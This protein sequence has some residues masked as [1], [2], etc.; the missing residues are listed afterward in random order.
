ML[1]IFFT[2]LLFASYLVSH[3]QISVGAGQG[4]STWLAVDK[5]IQEQKFQAALDGTKIIFERAQ[6]EKNFLLQ[7]EA[8]VRSAQ[9]EIGLG[10]FEGAVKNFRDRPWPQQAEAQVLLNLY[11][12]QSLMSYSQRYRWE[13]SH[14][15]T[16]ESKTPVDLKA[17]TLQDLALEIKK[18]LDVALTYSHVMQQPTS[19]FFKKYVA[20]GT[21]PD[22][23][24][25]W[26]RN[27]VIDTATSF[28]ADT[29][30]W[31]PSQV[32]EIY[33]ISIKSLLK[34]PRPQRISASELKVHPVEMMASWLSENRGFL[35]SN[36]KTEAAL[37]AQYALIE[38]L[39]TVITDQESRLI[40]LSELVKVQ[41]EN[42]NNRWWSRGQAML[43]GF[44]QSL[45]EKKFPRR[46]MDGLS[47]AEAGAKAF[48]GSIGAQQCLH[49]IS[50]IRAPDYAFQNMSA[51]TTQRQSLSVRYKNI[52]KLFFRAYKM[53]FDRQ[54]LRYKGDQILGGRDSEF[55][56]EML[57][58]KASYEWSLDLEETK[59]FLLHRRLVQP[60][61]QEKGYYLIYA[62]TQNDFNGANDEVHQT[63]IFI[64]DYVL[65]LREYSLNQKVE[66]Q[67]LRGLD[68]VGVAEV[69]VQLYRFDYNK[70][71]ASVVSAGKSDKNGIVVFSRPPVDPHRYWN[72]FATAKKDDNY[73]LISQVN[74]P[75]NYEATRS[76]QSMIFI[77]RA[78]YRPGQKVQFKMS[79]FEGLKSDYKVVG[80]GQDVTVYLHDPNAQEVG[81]LKLTTN[82]FGTV[83]GEFVIPSGRPLGAWRLQ[84]S[85]SGFAMLRVEEYKRPTFE[86]NL[87]DPTQALH[88]N[89]KANLRGEAKYFFGQPVTTGKIRYR[90]SRSM[91]VFYEDS[92]WRYLVNAISVQVA[93]GEVTV[94]SN[95]QFDIEFTPQG[96]EALAK[97]EDRL[98]YSYTV[99][100][101]FTDEGGE[102]RSASRSYRIGFLTLESSLRFNQQIFEPSEAIE[103][104][105]VLS[106]LDGKPRSGFANYKIFSVQQ[107]Q[108]TLLPADLENEIVESPYIHEHDK[109]RAR[110][111]V[112]FDAHQIMSRWPIAGMVSSGVFKHEANGIAKAI[113]KDFLNPGVYRLQYEI[114]DDFG[115]TFQLKKDFIIGAKKSPALPLVL[116]AKKEIYSVGSTAQVFVGSGFEDQEV[117]WQVYRGKELIQDQRLKPNRLGFIEI[118]I[119]PKDRGGFEIRAHVLRDYQNIELRQRIFVPWDDKAL[120]LEIAT[121][122]DRVL[123]G[124]KEVVRLTVKGPKGELLTSGGA[125]VL[126]LMYDR[127]LDLFAPYSLSDFQM[128]YPSYG[129]NF[130]VRYSNQSNSGFHVWGTFNSNSNGFVLYNSNLNMLSGYAIGG[131]GQR[132]GLGYFEKGVPMAAAV[133]ESFDGVV[134]AKSMN[135]EISSKGGR[136]REMADD[137]AKGSEILTQGSGGGGIEK[138]SPEQMRSNFSETAFFKPQLLLDAKGGVS[139]EYQMPDSLTSWK[140]YAQAMTKDMLSGLVG[141]EV[142]SFKELMV[143]PYMPRFLREG[144][145]AEI[146]VVVSNSSNKSMQGK[147]KLQIEDSETMKAANL[148]FGLSFG[149]LSQDFQ[150]G[151]NSSSHVNFLVKAPAKLKRYSFRVVAEV[152]GVSDGELREL[153]I[154]PSRMHLTQSRF[155]SLKGN[156]SKSVVFEDLRSANKDSTMLQD[157]LVATVDA[158]L[159]FSLLQALPSILNSPYQCSE[160]I[161]NK[162][163]T[164]GI[165]S[166][167][168]N[169]YPQLAKMAK[170]FS[171]RKTALE[172]FNEADAN[173]RMVL[174]ES[175]W[176]NSARGGVENDE[177][178]SNVLDP[179][180]AKEEQKKALIKLKKMQ[181]DSGAFPWFE[182]GRPDEFMTLYMLIGFSR[183]LEFKA[184]VPKEAVV[185][186]WKYT[187]QWIEN[188]IGEMVAK[189]Y[190]WEMVTTVLFALSSYPDETWSGGV[191]TSVFREK[192]LNFS[193]SHWKEHAPRVKAYLALVLNRE[194]RTE[195]AKLVWDSIMDSA[196]TSEDFGTYWQPEDR[197]WIWYRDT[198]ESQAFGLRS[199][200]ELARG[201]ART[202]G[203]VQWLFLNKKLN[204]W[205]STRATAEVIYSVAKYLEVEK[206]IGLKEEILVD[207]GTQSTSMVFSPE[208][209]AGRKNQIV[210]EGP[211]LNPDKNSKI[212]FQNRSANLAFASATWHFSTERLPE[213]G[214]GDFFS[215][216]RT[217]FVRQNKSGR[218]QP[219]EWTLKPLKSGDV[220]KVGDQVEVQLSL[221]SKHEAEYV[222]VRDPRAAGLEPENAISGYK[223][224]QGLS[225][226]EEVRDSGSNFFMSSIPV[227]EAT[228]RYRLRANMAGTFRL[229]PATVQSFYAPEFN[230][231]SSGFVLK[232]IP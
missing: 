104:T 133:S 227:G 172:K 167:F 34:N 177:I 111:E 57:A 65:S 54:V 64:S 214:S 17:W 3:A 199:I 211:K 204:Q 182:G 110:Y 131:L 145:L 44:Y 173:R 200:M 165:L 20:K 149:S 179:V 52:S 143:R 128:I 16:I 46:M 108:K 55:Y 187:S 181:L 140:F 125:E 144:D 5:L 22:E 188:Q 58:S 89:K 73:A 98:N 112:S 192:L 88:L 225:W 129:G 62:A 86:V 10:S 18:S 115:K 197:A 216:E 92:Y 40:I 176:L 193:F 14:R 75:Q 224:G 93:Q 68:G 189:N 150:V 9:L 81:K 215:I 53:D 70:G 63:G 210:I 35:L 218:G 80:K 43:S 41:S 203:F 154:L 47:A 26:F 155:V 226:Y 171:K 228:F 160:L 185:K 202:E 223:W 232:V 66:I 219:G 132:S 84:S 180:L 23:V 158:Q 61:I 124:A 45:P 116:F 126:A 139:F 174:E 209:Y 83:A 67:V 90:I 168:Y 157:R 29:N 148:D 114:Q 38:F 91:G 69:P 56:K 78:I 30:F 212:T 120:K 6:K 169:Q 7:A 135:A 13:I 119:A 231:Y 164:T 51:D 59:D 184:E 113:L 123:P 175:P 127:S 21:F 76:K 50:V 97:K 117:D 107:P 213:K 222:H 230:A 194:K 136:S 152:K 71:D 201:D 198:V 217:Y 85:I 74:F 96:E 1:R 12:A 87:L 94:D 118:P 31:T 8:M 206:K 101:D 102:T 72:Y 106:Q 195:S 196:K 205:K 170:Q 146:R 28:F 32:A 122:R 191:F 105:A 134:S 183:A 82:E 42:R 186:A 100:V 190:G 229:S 27:I 48:P 130:W 208:Q 103:V 151:S 11:Y 166:S 15:E 159:F 19:E 39:Q 147:V 163:L 142:Q 95:G 207:M 36:N 60:P 121:M 49:H 79:V 137:R 221:R 109:K 33:K 156:Q 2:S 161:L 141:K 37:E 138:K 162:Y 4:A 153:P 24:K 99:Q 178:L 25:P 77:D 220:V